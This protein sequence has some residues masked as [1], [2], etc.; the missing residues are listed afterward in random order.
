MQ[1]LTRYT[2]NIIKQICISFSNVNVF[3]I[4]E[5]FH[6]SDKEQQQVL[7]LNTNECCSLTHNTPLRQQVSADIAL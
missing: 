7:Q 1:Q 5:M 3:L 4:K 2:G 6:F